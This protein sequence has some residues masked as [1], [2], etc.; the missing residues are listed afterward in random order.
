MNLGTYEIETYYVVINSQTETRKRIVYT[1]NNGE[2]FFI[3][4]YNGIV[5]DGYRGSNTNFKNLYWSDI[6]SHIVGE[7]IVIND[8]SNP[9]RPQI[10]LNIASIES[11]QRISENSLIIV[12][13]Q[14]E[15]VTLEFLTE[16]DCDQSYSILNYLL[17][18]I[19]F[20]LNG[21]ISDIIPPVIFFNEY[22]F[23]EY[24][25]IDSQL[26]QVDVG[27]F[28]T[29]DGTSV[30][31]NIDLSIF[32]GPIPISKSDII[33]GLIYDIID[34]R[35]GSLNLTTNDISLY[36]DSIVSENLVDEIST[37]GNYLCRFHLH[38]LGQN[39]NNSTIVFSVV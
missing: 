1:G 3:E 34:N 5:R 27:Q 2:D 4:R 32:S 10:Y 13:T 39:Q 24:V 20:N 31:I 11:I 16:F 23:S 15:P 8:N 12:D 7:S 6:K 14:I 33:D 37:A 17:Q 36:K 19:D 26:R 21:S 18:N 30:V 9:P 35:D 28:S 29:E 22:F 25:N 38:D